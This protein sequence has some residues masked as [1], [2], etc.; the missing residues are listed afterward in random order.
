M[1]P[2][3]VPWYFWLVADAVVAASA[4]TV[5]GYG[6]RRGGPVERFAAGAYAVAWLG[7]IIWNCLP[8]VP[9]IPRFRAAWELAWLWDLWLGGV[10]LY[11]AIRHRNGWMAVAAMAQ[12]A[13]MGVRAVELIVGEV[14]TAF[15]VATGLFVSAMS[16][17]MMGCILGSTLSRRRRLRREGGVAQAPS[18]DGRRGLLRLWPLAAAR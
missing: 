17:V 18:F 5:S 9:F 1:Q 15:D 3:I 13:Q 14:L 16:L 7:S 12:G 2:H 6:L 11:L 8:L 10:F 4:L